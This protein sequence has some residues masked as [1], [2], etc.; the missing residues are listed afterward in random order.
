MPRTIEIQLYQF[1][2]LTP[3]RIELQMSL[4]EAESASHQGQCD[5]DVKALSE[6]PHIAAQLADID[7]DTLRQELKEYGAWDA[8][9]LADHEQNLQRLLWLAAGD[10]VEEA[11]S[12]ETENEHATDEANALCGPDETEGEE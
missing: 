10:I 8:D 11:R 2:E 7:A 4:Q 1:D 3:A 9:Q 5:D 12:A 6:L